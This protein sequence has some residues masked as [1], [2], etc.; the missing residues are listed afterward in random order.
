M[1]GHSHVCNHDQT[2]GS[3]CQPYIGLIYARYLHFRFLTW[4]LRSCAYK[5]QGLRS[6]TPTTSPITIPQKWGF[7]KEFVHHIMGA[8][9]YPSSS[10]LWSCSL[11]RHASAS[12]KK[13]TTWHFGRTAT[14][15]NSSVQPN[16]ADGEFS[17]SRR[18]CLRFHPS[19][20][21][22]TTPLDSLSMS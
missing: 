17:I 15:P 2:V 7:W 12:S 6:P 21:I 8:S 13:G 9:D 22:T 18:A 14:R 20:S 5:T 1:F 16:F 11:S 10:Y 3:C 4:P 19:P